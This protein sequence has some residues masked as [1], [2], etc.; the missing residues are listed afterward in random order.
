MKRKYYPMEKMI[1]PYIKKLKN[2][3]MSDQQKEHLTII[4][5]H[6]TDIISPFFNQMAS[7]YSSLT[8]TEIEIAGYVKD[9]KT[10]KEIV[11]LVNSSVGAINFHRNNLREKLGIKNSKMNLKTYLMSIE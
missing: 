8:P 3:D 5:S 9:G 11:N 7:Q 4:E 6:I 1:L 10:T 2:S